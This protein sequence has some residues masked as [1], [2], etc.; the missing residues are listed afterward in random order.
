MKIEI[1]YKEVQYFERTMQVEMSKK[2]YNDYIKL[3]KWEQ[4]QKYNLCA[5]TDVENWVATE[6]FS[7]DAE[8]IN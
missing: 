3:S 8:I 7:I 5:D 6:I 4:D 2:E 1:T